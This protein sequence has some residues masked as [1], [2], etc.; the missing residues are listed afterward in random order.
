M[1]EIMS[2]Q[3]RDEK[4]GFGEKKKKVILKEEIQKF[5]LCVPFTNI[6]QSHYV[7]ENQNRWK[8]VL[9]SDTPNF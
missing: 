6:V 5:I 1:Q 4:F 9:R 7:E 3:E 8:N 2:V